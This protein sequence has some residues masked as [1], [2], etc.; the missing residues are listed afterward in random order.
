MKVSRIILTCAVAVAL[1]W[2]GMPRAQATSP[3]A[4]FTQSVVGTTPFVWDE[5]AVDTGDATF[6]AST[7][8]DFADLSGLFGGDMA[9]IT[10]TLTGSRLGDAVDLGGI[11]A[12]PISITSIEFMDGGTL[13]LKMVATGVY[14]GLDGSTSTS[15]AGT[16]VIGDTVVYSSDIVSSAVLN[17]GDNDYSWGLTSL[18]PVFALDASTVAV[19]LADH[20]AS[21]AGVF[22]FT[23][24]V[25]EPGTL[26]MVVGM[27]VS[28]SLF[29]LRLRRRK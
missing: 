5:G 19:D 25:P 26:A 8:V 2:C 29:S 3:L 11:L 6:S 14:S 13:V 20:E 28:G 21:I 1:A 10:M 15:I 24:V 4:G 27:G 17:G 22:G 9:G 23:P 16:T 12:Q 7:T 18:S